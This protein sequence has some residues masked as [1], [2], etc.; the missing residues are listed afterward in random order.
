[1]TGASL[2]LSEKHKTQN[3]V[4]DDG[5][6]AKSLILACSEGDAGK[7][8]E[9]LKNG[10]DP[11]YQSDILLYG[12]PSKTF[13][14]LAAAEFVKKKVGLPILLRKHATNLIKKLTD[15]GAIPSLCERQLLETI[16]ATGNDD[17]MALLVSHH[18]RPARH[19]HA[20]ISSAMIHHHPHMIAQLKVFGVDPNIKDGWGSSPLLDICC[21]QLPFFHD[22][23]W[24]DT[25]EKELWYLRHMQAL[26][27]VG[28]DLNIRDRVGATPLMRAIVSGQIGIAKALI[29]AGADINAQ[30][31]N[32]VATIHLAAFCT[33]RNFMD[34][35]MGFS[36]QR[37]DLVRM[38]LKRLQ[39]DV[40]AFITA[41]V[42]QADVKRIMLTDEQRIK[43]RDQALLQPPLQKD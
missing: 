3:V 4:S 11:N 23:H 27:H 32:G 20:L 10:A 18:A 16:A 33:N 38:T 12:I 40:K 28:V 17:A 2:Q 36:P 15:A 42:R 14:L 43:M 37:N 13:P 29:H 21:A 22:H 25:H 5:L 1:M 34:F 19:A 7:I 41:N 31:K 6:L 30:L 39:P 24:A 26:K 35:M 8:D 9:L